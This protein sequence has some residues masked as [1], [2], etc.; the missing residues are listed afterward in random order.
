[1]EAIINFIKEALAGKKMSAEWIVTLAVAIAGV[2][3]GGTLAYQ[4]YEGMVAQLDAVTAQAHEQ[5]VPYD[6]SE[7][8]LKIQLLNDGALQSLERDTKFAL[9]VD[10]VKLQERVNAIEKQADNTAKQVNGSGNPLAL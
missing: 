3:W 10:L 7:L 8:R 1:M 2:V 4:K 9:Q 6:D 5:T